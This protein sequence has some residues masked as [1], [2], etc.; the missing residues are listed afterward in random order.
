MKSKVLSAYSTIGQYVGV[1]F[2]APSLKQRRALE[3]S[4]V[5]LGVA[6]LYSGTLESSIAQSSGSGG[7]FTSASNIPSGQN[8]AN[9]QRLELVLQKIFTYLEGSFGALVMVASGLGAI[10]SSA[11]GQFKAALGLLVVAVGAFILRSLVSTFFTTT[12]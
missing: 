1:A 10:I 9:V 4:M 6:L 3:I 11:F 7:G 8:G 12:I 5:L 2:N